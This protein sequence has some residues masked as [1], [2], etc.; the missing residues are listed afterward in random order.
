MNIRER[1][2]EDISRRRFS[3]A[4]CNQPVPDVLRKQRR[5]LAEA[6]GL[7]PLD[8]GWRSPP[9]ETTKIHPTASEFPRISSTAWK[10]CKDWLPPRIPAV[11][12]FSREPRFAGRPLCG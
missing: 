8:A 3:A 11:G 10:I 4:S 6:D 7:T 2:G 9:E 5:H 1:E 12:L